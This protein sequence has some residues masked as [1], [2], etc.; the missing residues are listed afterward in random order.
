MDVRTFIDDPR[1]R[2]TIDA[3][4]RDAGDRV[5]SDIV[6]DSGRQY[7]DLVMEG[8]GVLGIALVGYTYALECLGIRFL[9]IGGTS[10]GSIN[11]LLMAA[12]DRL[13]QPKS[14]RILDWLAEIDLFAFVDGDG[15]ARRM[16]EAIVEKAG[17]PTL[18]FRG[19]QVLDNLFGQLGL[20]PGD[21]FSQWIKERLAEVGIATYRDLRERMGPSDGVRLRSRD[22]RILSEGELDARLSMVAAE[23]TTESKVDF[24]R[25]AP[26]YWSDPDRVNPAEFVR[27][28]MSI[29]VLFHPFRVRS[30]PKGPSAERQWSTLAHYSGPIPDEVIFVDG[31]TISNFPI[32]LFHQPGVP[33]APTFGVKLGLE[34]N[35]PRNIR[36]PVEF[37]RALFEAARNG[38][39]TDFLVKHRDYRNLIA[40]IQTGEHYW[41]DFRLTPEAKV[42]LFARGVETAADFVRRFD[43]ERYKRIRANLEQAERES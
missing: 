21:V 37:L 20:N 32:D 7:V 17:T 22:G 1:V 23:L 4:R 36:G 27:A 12:L 30:L 10:A 29:P 38:A 13:D 41:L 6:D 11:A 28:S 39:D 8:G 2:A 16:V 33:L 18:V 3:L 14:H 9:G 42:D 25:M 24:P 26:L 31:G 35:A 40:Y 15:D 5:L 34:R 19:A 43:W